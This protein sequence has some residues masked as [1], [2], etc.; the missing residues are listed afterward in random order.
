MFRK[1]LLI[2][3]FLFIV[4][5]L[6]IAQTYSESNSITIP[7]S[8]PIP[9]VLEYP[10]Y[11]KNASKSD[12][13]HFKVA[14]DIYIENRIAIPAGT[15]GIAET[16]KAKKRGCWGRAGRLVVR[17]K[18][19]QLTNGVTIPLMAPDIEK[20]GISKKANAW[21]WFFCSILFVP[22]NVIPPLC[23]KGEDIAMEEGLVIL[24]Y[25]AETV[26]YNSN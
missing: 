5:N 23:I 22:L 14:Q 7:A 9:L 15:I 10:I 20:K 16:I 1:N 25:T 13:I 17:I 12:L 11:S 19:L 6:C 8:T 24:A 18:E 2:L 21:T 4:K 3:S 26:R